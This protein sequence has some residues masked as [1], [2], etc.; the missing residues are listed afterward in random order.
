M[1]LEQIDWPTLERLRSAFLNGCAGEHDYWTTERD[2]TSYD[3]TF[4]QRIGWKWD[5]VL[6]ELERRGWTPPSGE[7]LD[8]GCGSGI[9][10]RAFL[11]HF[12][13]GNRSLLLWDRSALA[14]RFASH[15][16]QDRFPGLPVRVASPTPV[17]VDILLLSHVLTELDDEQ[18]ERVVDLAGRATAVL[19][20]EPGTHAVSRKLIEL[21]ERLRT[22]FQLVAP[23]PHQGACGMLA[24]QNAP[25]WCHHFASP[26]PEVFTDG[27]WARFAQLTGVDLRS[28]PL[29]FLVLDK[30]TAPPLPTGAVRIIGRPR[31][32]KAHALLLGCDENGVQERQLTKRV[33]PDQFRL[34]KKGEPEPLQVWDY[35]EDQIISTRNINE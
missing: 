25:H 18:V 24:E 32:Y 6:S 35:L 34:L 22:S 7:V 30:R 2:L 26:P 5:Y 3:Q 21:S 13:I 16:A 11:D 23:C 33:L 12:G 15:R 10:G 19:W 14:V 8:W 17:T 20:V 1:D 29:S 4:A 31:T 27:N 9:A 28:L